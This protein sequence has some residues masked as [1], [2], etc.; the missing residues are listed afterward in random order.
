ML[1]EKKPIIEIKDLCFQYNCKKSL[2]STCHHEL[3]C[4]LNIQISPNT[5]TTILG[6]N[7]GGKSTLIKLL[8]GILR[9]QKGS[10][11]YKKNDIQKIKRNVLAQTI[12]Y[13]PQNLENIPEFK[14]ID[15]VS[16]GRNPYHRIFFRLSGQEKSLIEKS[17]N[18]TGLWDFRNHYLK[19]L[20]GGQ[21]QRAFLAMALVQ[22]TPIIFLDEPTTYLDIKYQIEFL[23]LLKSMKEK[24]DKTIVLI[25]HDI[26]LAAIYSDQ[27][28]LLHNNGVLCSGSPKEVLNESNI[29]EIFQVRPKVIEQEI[30]PQFIFDPSF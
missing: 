16:L 21:R 9:P 8:A 20:S 4:K 30:Y 22:D 26:N 6:K 13:L 19:E 14:V 23:N 15:L 17:L 28:V 18:L 11:L 27:I 25:L 7:G 3:L 29:Q 5:I 2:Q 1:A 12:S 24:E 10:I